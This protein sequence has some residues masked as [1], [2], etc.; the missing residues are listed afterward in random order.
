LQDVF[1]LFDGWGECNGSDGHR[2]VVYNKLRDSGQIRLDLFTRMSE[3][4]RKP[5][6]AVTLTLD[7]FTKSLD[8]V[9]VDAFISD[10]LFGL[11]KAL[12]IVKDE[13]HVE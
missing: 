3:R 4:I 6:T 12:L 2:N 8:L 11:W 1:D 13:W 9:N 5:Q 10:K 7:G